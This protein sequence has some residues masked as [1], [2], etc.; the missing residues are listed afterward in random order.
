MRAHASDLPPTIDAPHAV[1]PGAALPRLRLVMRLLPLQLAQSLLIAVALFVMFDGWNRDFRVPLGFVSDS[2]WYLAQTKSTVDNGWWWWNPR[3]GA[4][5]G[6]DEVSFPSNSTVD[7]AVVWVVSR[8]VPDAF[9][10][11]NLT[12]ALLVVL[13]GLTATW[14]SR[15]LGVSTAGAFVA[16][17]LFALSPYALYRNIDH[18]ALVIYLV[19][20]ACAAALWLAAGE[21]HQ[22]W[23]RTKRVVV[24]AGCVL[25]GINYVYFAFFG[26]FC[27]LVGALIGYF[28][29]RDTRVLASGALCLA[30]IAGS[31]VVNLSPT[32]Y[33][34]YKNGQPL[35]VREKVPAE[36]EVFG[37]KIR[38][39]LSPVFPHRFQPFNQWVEREAAARFP[40]DNENWTAR[41]GVVAAVGFLGLLVLLLVPDA[42]SRGV[43]LLQGASKLTVAALLLGTVGGFGAVFNLAVSSDIRAYNRISVFITFFSLLAVV[44]AIDRLFKSTRARTAAIAAVLLVGLLDQGQ[45]TRR[46]NERHAGIAAEV[47]GLRSLVATLEGA[48][49]AGAMVFQLPVRAY[50]S[51]SDFGRMKQYDQFKPYLVSKN[52]RFSYPAFSNEQVRWQQAMT[53]LDMP[54]LASRL[55]EQRFAAVL[56]D[57]YGYEDQ[58]AA[59][60][61]GL[62]SSV[63]DDRVIVNTDR[64]LAV[65]IRGRAA[66][67]SAAAATSSQPVAMTLSMAACPPTPSLAPMV[68]VADQVDQIGESR[69][70][71]GTG[72]ARIRRSQDSKVSGWAVDGPRRAPAAAVDVVIDRIAFPT[73]YGIHRND[74]AEYFKRPNY[75]DTGFAAV[76]PANAIPRGEHWLSIRVVTADGGCYYESPGVRVTTV[77]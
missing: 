33:S 56:V 42:R 77:E 59:V 38:H 65:D 61:A 67:R 12:W 37:L 27:I 26:S 13:S 11:I 1:V 20:F 43:P 8:F 4:P 48:L 73:T 41:L 66:D 19:P 45:A 54:T 17:T 46:I 22:S 36:A 29:N 30:L 75:R 47:S 40:N 52:L 32:F 50:M 51:E 63:A 21:P 49:P 2:L 16:G 3:I 53:R 14:C 31:T 34:W 7:Q 57:R 69:P 5:H 24:F 18:F 55:G 76:I 6:L 70:P 62:R 35:I 72:P 15:A 23:G 25:L 10:A 9:A 71:F 39:L 60:I 58:G 68:S 28:I 64:F 44:I 74:V